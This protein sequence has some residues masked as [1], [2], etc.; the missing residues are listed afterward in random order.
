MKVVFVS[1]YFNHHQSEFCEAMDKETKGNFVFIE[2]IP[3]TEE[4]KQMGWAVGKIPHYV[5]KIYVNDEE[6][7]KCE[8]WIT[9]ADIVIIGSAPNF[10]IS[11]RLK[12]KKIV[13]RYSERIYKNK[14]KILQIPLR[15]I[16]YHYENRFNNNV[17][18]LASSAYAA[19]DYKITRNF[20][21][22]AFK[23]GYF[24][25][26][27]IYD[28]VE[29]LIDRKV[30]KSILWVGRLIGLKHPEICI[31]IAKKLKDEG[32]QFKLKI[33]GKGEME[34][35]L[36]K[37]I[38]KYNLED[39]VF[40][41]GSM[42]P[43]KVREY[44]EKSEIFLFTSDFNEGWGAVLNE[45]MNSACA[46]IVSH[47]VGAAPFL[48]KDGVNGFLYKNGNNLELFRKIKWLLNNHS[49]RKKFSKEAYFTIRDEWNAYV[50]A[51]RLLELSKNLISESKKNVAI[52]SGPCSLAECI[53]NGWYKE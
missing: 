42:S 46:V 32:Y 20:V 16:K 27:I 35:A 17:Y 44:M 22:K 38:E 50:A 3:M 37:S 2:T 21:G 53:K 28:N 52:Q 7:A 10:L 4:R 31:E 49:A 8:K 15:A 12:R 47:A 48:V 39:N 5:K 41:L 40:L 11:E 26:T 24:P 33:I 19:F 51:K 30:P 14:W 13:F 45:A 34:E 9:D 6:R 23:W 18:L 36:M 29:S 1:N 25:K 43:E